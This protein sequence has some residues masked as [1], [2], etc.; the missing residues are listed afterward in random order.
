MAITTPFQTLFAVPMTCQ[1]CV[2]DISGSLNKLNGI[3]RVEANLKD[4]L[5]TIEGTAAPSA[6]VATIQSTGRDA[7][8]RGTG[9]SNSAAVCILETH[10][11]TVSDKVRGLARM[12]QVAPN[13]TLI[14]LT[15]RG[16]SPGNYWA[17]VRETGDI[18]NGAVS[19]RGIWNESEES[20]DSAIKH[21]GFL[22]TVQVGK[23][24]IGSVFLDKPV[25]IWEMIGRGMVVS[26][27]HDG[28]NEFERNDADTLVGVVARSAG[29]WDNDKTVCSC[30]GKTLWEER[31]DEV[32]KGML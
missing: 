31:K 16:L 24:G 5:V 2:N 10:S 8:L 18:S 11:T 3:Q 1:S 27:Q 6:I 17:T 32:K 21:K 28:D 20:K 12:V 22:G 15:I 23:D 26:K 14:D 4:Q 7:I 25:Q 9:G 30:S 13:L 29:V 19:T